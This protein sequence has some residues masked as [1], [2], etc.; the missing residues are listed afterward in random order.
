MLDGVWRLR[1]PLRPQTALRLKL[2]D[3]HN[4]QIHCWQGAAGVTLH[5]FEHANHQWVA[6]QTLRK[7]TEARPATIALEAT[8]EDRFWRTNPLQP[9]MFELRFE[10][11]LIT[12]V[13]GDVRVLGALPRHSGR[14][15]FRRPRDLSRDC[16][17]ARG[18]VARPAATASAADRLRSARLAPLERRT[19][20]R[21]R[22][23]KT[24]GRPGRA[25]GGEECEPAWVAVALPNRDSLCEIVC[26]LNEPQPGTGFFLG[27]DQGPRYPVQFFREAHRGETSFFPLPPGDARSDSNHDFDNA[28]AP[29][30]L[31]S[32]WFRL[33]FGCGTLK[34][35]DHADGTHWGRAF[36]PLTNQDQPYTHLGLY[37][38]ASSPRKSIQLRHLQLRDLPTINALAPAELRRQGTRTAGAADLSQWLASVVDAQ[39]I[40]SEPGPWRRACAIRTLAAGTSNASSARRCWIAFWTKRLRNTN[41]SR[42]G[43]R[44]WMR[45]LCCITPG[46]TGRWLCALP[47]ATNMSERWPI[48]RSA[49]AL[50]AHR[51]RAAG[52]S[53]LGPPSLQFLAGRAGSLRTIRVGPGGPMGRTGGFLPARIVLAPRAASKAAADYFRLGRGRRRSRISKRRREAPT[54]AAD[55]RHPLLVE[56]SKEGYNLLAEFR[57][58]LDG[59]SYR[60]ACQIISTSAEN[61]M[62]GLLPD[63]HDTDLLVSLPGAVALAMRDHP[64]LAATMNEQ[65]GPVGRLR[66][67][68]AIADNDVSALEAATIQFYGTEAAGEARLFLAERSLSGGA[69]PMP[70]PCIARPSNR[71]GLRFNL[72]SRRA[73]NWPRPCS[74][75][76]PPA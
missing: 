46:T 72:G 64:G 63:S 17:G 16:R 45:R 55:R 36:D 9:T 65:F 53:H 33:V 41:P 23:S 49:Q 67:R 26:Q 3:F 7:G 43:W 35:S 62:L 71:R 19:G 18:R 37:C 12:L 66:V 52:Q 61:G 69:S 6:Y 75:S 25:I 2:A 47:N 1:A 29:M 8:D 54:L 28:V 60:D 32:P 38:V 48:V 56:L 34:C 40:E 11:G 31:K 22:L 24:P 21:R 74:A 5:Y 10:P 4:L 30:S 70:W 76:V 73:S 59:R 15:L 57:A 39:P 50:L 44:C 68:Q 27:D 20:R 14:N 42:P 13:R 51:A 58:A